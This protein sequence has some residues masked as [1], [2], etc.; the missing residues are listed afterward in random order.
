M[1][2]STRQEL[3]KEL[4]VRTLNDDQRKYL[5]RRINGIRNID[6]QTQ[7]ECGASI[8]VL[9]VSSKPVKKCLG[10]GRDN[11]EASDLKYIKKEDLH[12]LSR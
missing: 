12:V 7:C 11:F 3:E 6:Y 1:T 2:N 4:T 10:C 9:L 8:H 5:I